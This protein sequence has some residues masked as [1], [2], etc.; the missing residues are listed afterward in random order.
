MGLSLKLNQGL[1]KMASKQ[2]ETPK[3]TPANTVTHNE[4]TKDINP[5]ILKAIEDMEKLKSTNSITRAFKVKSK[6]KKFGNQ[7]TDENKNPLFNQD[8]TPQKWNDRF[9]LT[10]S[11]EDGKI[12]IKVTEE[13]FETITVGAWYMAVGR[14]EIYTPYEGMPKEIIK[15]DEFQPLMGVKA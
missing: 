13:I 9:L 4:F 15:Y 2:T 6:E 10:S 14:V 7:K 5:Q 12:D 8:G 1:H 3:E 11:S